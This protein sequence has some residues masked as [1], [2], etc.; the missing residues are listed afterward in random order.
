MSKYEPIQCC[1]TCRHLDRSMVLTCYPPKAYCT[2]FKESVFIDSDK[3][4]DD[5]KHLKEGENE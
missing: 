4:I 3:C 1:K 5:T 2:L